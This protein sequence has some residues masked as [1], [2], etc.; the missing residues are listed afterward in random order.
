MLVTCVSSYVY[1]CLQVSYA[2]DVCVQVS[3]AGD[4]CLKVCVHVSTGVICW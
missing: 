1:V 2:G 4:M 3:Y